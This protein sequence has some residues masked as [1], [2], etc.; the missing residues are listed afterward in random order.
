MTLLGMFARYWEPGAVKTRL[1]A[2]IGPG[3]ASRFHQ[4]S[5]QAL[6]ARFATLADRRQLVITPSSRRADFACVSSLWSITHQSEGDLGRR[7]A[8]FFESAAQVGAR[9]VVLIGSDSPTLPGE[10]LERAFERLLDT[11]VVLGPAAD[12]GYYLVG[13]QTPAPSL[14][15]GI[16]W[17]TSHVWD[18]TIERLKRLGIR[19]SEL[20]AWYD[21]DDLPGLLRLH[22]ELETAAV[23]D[24]L[25]ELRRV[26][27]DIVQSLNR[28]PH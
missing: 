12:G 7:M 18:Q 15:E 25:T 27:S 28:A 20:P 2:S 1:A 10:Y 24:A 21:I 3:W 22:N 4:A 13:C 17:S 9:R 8:I 23:D 26:V 6:A 16:A 11:P 14:F 19:Y 5:V